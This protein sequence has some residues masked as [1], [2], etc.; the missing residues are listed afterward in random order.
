MISNNQKSKVAAA[1]TYL[2]TSP[3]TVGKQEEVKFNSVRFDD[4]GHAQHY[5]HLPRSVPW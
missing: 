2:G 1:A 3:Y 4:Q 5:L